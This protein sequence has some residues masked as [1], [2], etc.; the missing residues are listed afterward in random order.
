MTKNPNAVALGRKGG[1]KQ[2][3]AQT[4]ARRANMAKALTAR[5]AKIA[6]REESR[7]SLDTSKKQ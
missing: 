5:L 2:T 4:A 1:L 6:E 3:E 7:L